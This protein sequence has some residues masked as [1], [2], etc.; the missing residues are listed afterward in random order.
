M[1]FRIF[2]KLRFLLSVAALTGVCYLGAVEV[3]TLNIEQDA[4][5]DKIPQEMLMLTMRLR[6]GSQYTRE[7]L[8]QDIKNLYA[9]GKV[10]DVVA[11]VETLKNGNVAIRFR[12]KPSPVISILK[13][14]GNVKFETRELQKHFTVNEGER[15]NGRQLNETLENLRKFY[16]G[17]GYAD[18]RIA[19]PAVIPDGKNGVIVTVKIEE[20][21]RL[22]VN[23]VSFENAT[24]FTAR[25][26][27]KQIFN[28]YSYWTMLPFI[29]QYFNHGLLHRN[30][31]ELDKARLR[32]LYHD[33]GYLDFKVTDV[34]LTPKERTMI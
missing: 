9:T 33:R 6:P 22:K 3:E 10:A 26:L 23:E 8:D 18:V 12:I 25:E 34:V 28:S 11:N 2:G 15:L 32:D 17:K 14:E 1:K 19:P 5:T 7:Y 29:N 31:L 24:I 16:T 13:I 30:E 21:L 20:N 27:R 4:G